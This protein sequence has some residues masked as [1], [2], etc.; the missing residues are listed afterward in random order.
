[1]RFVTSASSW[2]VF[3]S[4]LSPRKFAIRLVAASADELALCCGQVSAVKGGGQIL[5][6][7][8]TVG[9]LAARGANCAIGS[10]MPTSPDRAGGAVANRDVV[11]RSL[12][13]G[14]DH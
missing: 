5:A 7:V 13:P 3:D 4:V 9:P 6:N 12:Y 8:G 11:V 1:M 2:R 10:S 14:F